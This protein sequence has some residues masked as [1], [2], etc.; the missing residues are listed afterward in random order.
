M[1]R[2]LIYWL[3]ILKGKREEGFT[4]IELLVVLIIIGILSGIALPSF[5]GQANRSRVSEAEEYMGALARAQQSYYVDEGEYAV[6]DPSDTRIPSNSPNP[7]FVRVMNQLEIAIPVETE[8]YT[9]NYS[10]EP[11]GF[12][13][14]AS[15]KGN[16][17]G[18]A[19]K[20]F[21]SGVAPIF[22]LC[23][24]PEG[25]VPDMTRVDDTQQCPDI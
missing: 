1:N 5:I 3:K 8:Y 4:L 19:A 9:Y 23:R 11:D 22:K 10:S 7:D 2:L 21:I 18:V 14:T 17:R 6:G 12:L 24:G 25:A 15:P 13:F 16:W 20:V